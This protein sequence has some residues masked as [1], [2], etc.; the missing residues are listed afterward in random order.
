MLLTLLEIGLE[1]FEYLVENPPYAWFFGL[2]LALLAVGIW[3]KQQVASLRT[4]SVRQKE[5]I[6][7]LQQRLAR[8]ESP[9]AMPEAAQATTPLPDDT[10]IVAT[11]DSGPELLWDLPE[12]LPAAAQPEADIKPTAQPIARPNPLNTAFEAAKHWLLGGNTVLR[13]GAVVLFMGLAFLLRY[14]TEGIVVPI[15]ARYASVAASAMA[16]LGLGWWL[17]QRNANFALMMQ[18]TGVGVLYLTV[19]GAIRVHE[20]LDP[21]LGF[22]LLV[23]V[24]LFSTMLAVTQNSLALACAATIGGFAAPILSSTGQGS[25]VM[26]FSYF[27][28]LNAGIFAIAWLKAWRLLNLIGFVGTF[29]IGF[30]WGLRSYKPELFWSVEP[31]LILFFLMYLAIGLLFARHKLQERNDAP[32]DDSRESMLRWSRRQGDYVDGTLLFGTPLAGFGLQYALTRD[33]E[34]GTAFSALALG[35]LYMGIARL[36]SGRAPG[37]ALLLVET[38]LALG[39]VFATLAIPLGLGAQW[40]TSAW[41]IEGAAIFWLGLRQQRVLARGF[42]LLLQV[43]AGLAFIHQMFQWY[44]LKLQGDFWTPMIIAL[45]ALLSALFV[46][47][48]KTLRYLKDNVLSGMLLVWGSLWWGLAFV[49]ALMRF[50]SHTMFPTWLLL[51]VAASTGIWTLLALRWRWSGLAALSL[52]LTPVSWVLLIGAMTDTYHLF[53]HWAWVGWGALLAVH[54]FSLRRL[55]DLLPRKAQ[56]LAHILGCWLTLFILSVE[57]FYGVDTLVRSNAPN[58]AWNTMASTLLPSLYLIAMASSR[59]WIWPVTAH[60]WAYRVW[61]ALPVALLM[62]AW[63]W[64]TNYYS[65][66]YAEPLPYMPLLNPL[67]LALSFALLGIVNWTRNKLPQLGITVPRAEQLAVIIAGASLFALI[68]ATVLRT[69]RHWGWHEIDP[70]LDQAVLSIVWTLMALALMIGGHIRRQREIWITGALLI[71]V[72]VAKL[73]LVE[74]SERGG[75]ARIVSFIGVGVLLLVVGYFAPLPPKKPTNTTQTH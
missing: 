28:L 30:A 52:W 19:L 34:F 40:T 72:V 12:E 31:F 54:L 53:A 11:Q 1:T 39:V 22:V 61:A 21:S 29:G 71:G 65:R 69:A 9:L 2:S 6:E 10:I 70:M 14:A 24:M 49:I 25:H 8:L 75:M 18:G 7:T 38:C 66:G 73:F 56:S 58:S 16:L 23:A 59:P 63:F 41:A 45:V 32:D 13:V 47:R 46:H 5:Q 51:S 74:L 17:R 60:A 64:L 37:R 48:I 35:L 55:A 3:L 36:L 50:S 27:A 67:D 62:L 4:E 68:T 15:E 33:M 44:S 57:L 43:A 26:L 20:L 42:G